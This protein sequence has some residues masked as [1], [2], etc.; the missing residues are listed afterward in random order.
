M[1]LGIRARG[2]EAPPSRWRVSVSLRHS[3]SG[4]GAMCVG[5]GSISAPFQIC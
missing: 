3:V 2:N 4:E 1:S 5:R